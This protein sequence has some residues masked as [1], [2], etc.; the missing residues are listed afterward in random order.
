MTLWVCALLTLIALFGA[1][2][3]RVWHNPLAWL[4]ESEPTKQTFAIVDREVGGTANV[5]LL[6]KGGEHGMYDLKLLRG[7]EKLKEHLLSY[8]HPEYGQLIGNVININDIVKET[9][10]AFYGEEAGSYR[11]PDTRPELSQLLLLFEN[12]GPDQLRRIA[13]NDLSASQMTLRLKWLEAT[14]YQGFT[15]HIERGIKEHIPA[16]AS[17]EPTG[18]VYTLVSTVG[19]LLLDLV[20]SFG[21]ALLIITLIMTLMLKSLRLGALSMVPNLIPIIWLMGFMG[22]VG[23]T[24]DM[25]NIL[26][27]SIAIGLAVD[28]T[29]HLLHHFRVHYEESGDPFIAINASLKHA[30]RAM[31]VTSSIL[32]LGFFAYMAAEMKNIQVFGLLIG[33]CAALAMLVDLIFG[34]A[35]LRTFYRRR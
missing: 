14:A 20:R 1:S 29:I 17:V 8:R 30:G 34:P 4:P 27:A 22:F 31:V 7:I 16:H 35:L 28:D 13:T 3:L 15:E 11:L 25:N 12:T 19:K 24:I 2:K 33:L 10:R 26:I 6:I 23:I 5:Q 9:R 21:T 18:A 32:T